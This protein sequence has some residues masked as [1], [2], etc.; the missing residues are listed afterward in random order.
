[1]GE[2]VPLRSIAE[3]RYIVGLQVITRVVL[4]VLGAYAGMLIAGLA[5][6]LYAQP[7]M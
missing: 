5:L 1:M 4:S 6:D 2:M 7:V 3:L